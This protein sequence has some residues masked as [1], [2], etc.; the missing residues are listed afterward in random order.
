MT[1]NPLLLY[2]PMTV[3]RDSKA[4]SMSVDVTLS[5]VIN[6]IFLDTV[7]MKISLLTNIKSTPKVTFWWME[8]N[9]GGISMVSVITCTGLFLVVLPFSAWMSFPNMSS[10][11]P[12]SSMVTGQFLM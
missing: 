1:K 11:I 12:M 9:F 10:A 5:T 3:L 8:S 6:F 4:D 2:K 7:I